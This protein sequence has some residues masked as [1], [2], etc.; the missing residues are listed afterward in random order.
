ML[1]FKFSFIFSMSR[2]KLV[3]ISS[4][5]MFSCF[6]LSFD[7][8]RTLKLCM[9]REF[10]LQFWIFLSHAP[11]AYLSD[12]IIFKPTYHPLILREEGLLLEITALKFI[13][14]IIIVIIIIYNGQSFSINSSSVTFAL[15]FFADTD[16]GSMILDGRQIWTRRVTTKK[17][18]NVAFSSWKKNTNAYTENWTFC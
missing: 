9:A 14:I 5:W 1:T 4:T 10:T 17:K 7:C 3:W 2:S 12:S 16:Q 6:N 15:R 11:T 18:A 8:N 13:V